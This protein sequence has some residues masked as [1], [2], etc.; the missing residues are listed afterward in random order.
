MVTKLFKGNYDLYIIRINDCTNTQTADRLNN[1]KYGRSRVIQLA[2]VHY[3]ITI[4]HYTTF[5][6]YFIGTLQL[7]CLFRFVV[8]IRIPTPFNAPY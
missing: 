5:H 6:E 2:V 3:I 1:L 4:I 8:Y 7:M